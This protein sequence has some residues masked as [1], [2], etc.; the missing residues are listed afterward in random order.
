MFSK[1]GEKIHRSHTGCPP[2]VSISVLSCD[3][4]CCLYIVLFCVVLCCV[5]LCCVV[6][7]C[8][9]LSCPVLSCRVVS[10]RV[11]SCLVLSFSRPK[12]CIL[13]KAKQ[14]SRGQSF[15]MTPSI[16]PPLFSEEKMA[17]FFKK[18][19]ESDFELTQVFL[20]LSSCF[21]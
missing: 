7:S 6:L 20:T 14:Y 8:L 15:K 18:F 9:V 3:V 2:Q 17:E 1:L 21:F 16:D 11:V 19:D 5:V 12:K 13:A 10:C 4:F